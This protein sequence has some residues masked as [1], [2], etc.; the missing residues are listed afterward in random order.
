MESVEWDCGT[1][2]LKFELGRRDILDLLI[3]RLAFIVMC[4]QESGL[5]LCTCTSA[6]CRS[7]KGDVVNGGSAAWPDGEIY[8]AS[9]RHLRTF[10]I[11]MFGAVEVKVLG[12]QMREPPHLTRSDTSRAPPWRPVVLV[13]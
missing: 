3:A 5:A 9:S 10:L 13:W 11:L 12:P 2:H 4:L 6:I 8:Q 7:D 1:K